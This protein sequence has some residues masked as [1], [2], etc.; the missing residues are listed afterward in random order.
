MVKSGTTWRRCCDN[1]RGDNGGV[2]TSTSAT[3]GFV[4]L[5]CKLSFLNNNNVID[6]NNNCIS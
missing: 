3:C 1:G 5:F 4:H 2:V 6:I